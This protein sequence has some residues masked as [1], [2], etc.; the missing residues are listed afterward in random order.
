MAA[1]DYVHF[2]LVLAS[3]SQKCLHARVG[4]CYLRY[5]TSGDDS[6]ALHTV[7]LASLYTLQHVET[8]GKRYPLKTS[9]RRLGD[10]SSG[11]NVSFQFL[12]SHTAGYHTSPLPVM[13]TM[14]RKD[15]TI[16]FAAGHSALSQ[17]SLIVPDCYCGNCFTSMGD[18]LVTDRLAYILHRQGRH[19]KPR[20]KCACVLFRGDSHKASDRM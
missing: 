19:R 14:P 15:N 6:H 1:L 11:A 4:L 10:L 12:P 18:H 8:N 9:W 16:L 2:P 20:R 5:A 13:Y 3:T 7:S 17:C